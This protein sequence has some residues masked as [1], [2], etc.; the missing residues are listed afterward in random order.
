M[1]TLHPRKRQAA[2]NGKIANKHNGSPGRKVA[3]TLK[4]GRTTRPTG[5]KELRPILAD[6]SET[7]SP[8]GRSDSRTSGTQVDMVFQYLSEIGKNPLLS[9][10]EE[11]TVAR[12]L[13]R[14]RQKLRCRMLANDF[15]L[16]RAVE[17]LTGVRDGRL[18][19]DRIINIPVTCT[20]EKIGLRKHIDRNLHTLAC[21]LEKNAAHFRVVMDRRVPLPKRRQLWR[22]LT[23][24][25]RRAMRLVEE[26][27]IR[28][29]QLEPCF[30]QLDKMCSRMG[31]IRRV[32]DGV[33]HGRKA[34]SP[35]PALRRELCILM[36]ATGESPHTA[37]RLIRQTRPYRREYEEAKRILCVRNL[38]LVVSIAKRFQNRG[39]SLLDLIQEGNRGLMHAVGKFECSRGTKFSTYATWWIRQAIRVALP[40]QSRPVR[41]PAYLTTKMYRVDQ[42][43]QEAEHQVGRRPYLNEIAAAAHMSEDD[44]RCLSVVAKESRSLDQPASDN[45]EGALGDLVEDHRT[46]DPLGNLKQLELRGRLDDVMRVLSPRE[47]EVVC[48]RYG[49]TDGHSRTLAEVGVLLSVTRE[50]IR[51]IETRALQKLRSP[52]QCGGLLGFL[53]GDAGSR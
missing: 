4:D 14:N 40:G 15:V 26:L 22:T 32:L 49:L 13:Q 39:V 1:V 29:E 52:D 30:S 5:A 25:R 10:A 3:E 11:I 53:E 36:G 21:L 8:K 34:R 12:T 23:L 28:L 37:T 48:L 24:R 38:R 41:L 18:R 27:D 16:R 35:S 20:A 9:R 6:R 44:V 33:G 2:S 42:A 7:R 43:T 45:A 51:Q 47:H 17:L 31:T 50:R 19:L 46:T